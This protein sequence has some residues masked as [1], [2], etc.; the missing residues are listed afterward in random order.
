M[1]NNTQLSVEQINA[2]L[3]LQNDIREIVQEHVLIPNTKFSVAT[4]A[5]L[6]TYRKQEE[7]IANNPAATIE[8]RQFALDSLKQIEGAEAVFNYTRQYGFDPSNMSAEKIVKELSQKPLSTWVKQRTFVD[9][10]NAVNNTK[11]IGMRAVDGTLTGINKFANWVA[12]K[13]QK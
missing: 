3:Q 8:A 10:S 5:I 7:E 9:V 11:E 2:R 6:A 4:P 12:N 13:T 1:T